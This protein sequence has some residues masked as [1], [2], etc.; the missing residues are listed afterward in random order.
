MSDYLQH[1][2]YEAFQA[3]W[4]S[5]PS[6]SGLAAQAGREKTIAGK[7]D[8]PHLK[9]SAHSLALRSVPTWLGPPRSISY[10]GT[11]SAYF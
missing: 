9:T 4:L 5:S 2:Q 8:T 7:R 1:P 10:Q 6:I 11:I 3:H